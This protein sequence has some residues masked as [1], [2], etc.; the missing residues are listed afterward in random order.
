MSIPKFFEFFKD[1][2]LAVEDGELHSASEVRETIASAMGI[3]ASDRAEMLPS[4]K[5]STFDNR[6]AWARAY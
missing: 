4:G 5:Q 1:F 2:L 6:V 3:S